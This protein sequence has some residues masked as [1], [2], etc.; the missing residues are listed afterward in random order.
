MNRLHPPSASA[1]PGEPS[2]ET[3][4]ERVKRGDAD[5][6]D[7]LT[8]R[9]M[10]RAFRVAYRLLGHREDAEDLVQEVFLLVLERIDGFQAGRSFSPWFYRILVNRGLNSRKSR[11]LRRTEEV[12]EDAPALTVAPDRAAEQLEAREKLRAAMD[13]LPETQQTV[14]H[15]FELEGFSGREIAEILDLSDG[16]VRWHLHQARRT[17]RQALMMLQGNCS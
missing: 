9:H 14:V 12:P 10:Q 11:A 2:D 1:S 16:T 8:L 5:A 17:L 4:A 7:A 15:L 6:F 3:L 13:R